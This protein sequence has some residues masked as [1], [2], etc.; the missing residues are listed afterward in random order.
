MQRLVL[1][2]H[3]LVF[4]MLNIHNPVASN[5][6]FILS[7]IFLFMAITKVKLLKF[8]HV[9]DFICEFFVYYHLWLLLTLCT[10]FFKTP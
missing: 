1:I 5:I 7:H 4:Y 3:T 6:G 10:V 9:M 2:K 8:S